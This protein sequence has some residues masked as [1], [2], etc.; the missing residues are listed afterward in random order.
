M[1]IIDKQMNRL[2]NYHFSIIS[3][4]EIITLKMISSQLECQVSFLEIPLCNLW[5]LNQP[6]C[7]EHNVTWGEFF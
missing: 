1:N 5:Q 4:K 7:Y 6:F 2:I 3:V